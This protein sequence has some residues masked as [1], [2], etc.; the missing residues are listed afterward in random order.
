MAFTVTSEN[1]LAQR[2][3]NV[4]KSNVISVTSC[5]TSANTD[6]GKKNYRIF[7]LFNAIVNEYLETSAK[8][9]HDL[10]LILSIIFDKAVR[11]IEYKD[12]VF[13]HCSSTKK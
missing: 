4:R 7:F 3:K 11:I 12:I 6:I 2:Q 1:G 13:K 8:I 10:L 5:I 9:K